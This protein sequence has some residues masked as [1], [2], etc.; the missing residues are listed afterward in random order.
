MTEVSEIYKCNICNNTIWI[1]SKGAGELSCC[2]ETMHKQMENA[3]D[4]AQEKHIPIV[5][6]IDSGYKISVG[7]I[8]HPMETEHYIT[9][10]ALMTDDGVVHEKFF[11][12]G[13]KPEIIIKTTAK[14]IKTCEYCNKHGLWS[15][16]E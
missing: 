4:A 8:A 1:I 9:W 16:T 6:K 7:S 13:E 10:I 3:T 5:T 11:S 12:P 15:K 2:G 14:A